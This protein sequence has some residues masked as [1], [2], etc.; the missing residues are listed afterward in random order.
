MQCGDETCAKGL[1]QGKVDPIQVTV[2]DIELPCSL[3]YGLEQNR[4]SGTWIGSRSAE[5]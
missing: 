5:P 3:G 1:Q 2:N 4:L